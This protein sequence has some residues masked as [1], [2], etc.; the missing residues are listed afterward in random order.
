MNLSGVLLFT[1]LHGEINNGEVSFTERISKCAVE[2]EELRLDRIERF[3]EQI[4]LTV[5]A[6]QRSQLIQLLLTFDTFSHNLHSEIARERNDRLDDLKVLIGI[7]NAGDERTI[8]L[9]RVDREPVQITQRRV[10]SA[11]IVDT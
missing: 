3:R 6:L 1:D 4:T 2:D 5:L 11:E 8:D 7:I 9:Q 10:S